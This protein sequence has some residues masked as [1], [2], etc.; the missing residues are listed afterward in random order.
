SEFPNP[1]P[2]WPVEVFGVLQ[3]AREIGGDLYDFY[4]ID[5]RTLGVVVADVCEKGAPAALFMAHTSSMLRVVTLLMAQLGS[6]PTPSAVMEQVNEEMCRVNQAGMFVT[7]FFAMLDMQSGT[8]SFC[9]AGHPMP[10]RLGADG[11][12]GRLA[13]TSGI[14][15]GIEAGMQYETGSTRIEPGD[16]FFLYTDG[17]TEAMNGQREFFGEIRLQ[18]ALASLTRASP[19]SMV[20]TVV[21]RVR[22][23]VAGAPQADDIA[24]IAVRAGLLSAFGNATGASQ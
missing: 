17:V 11:G 5:D 6:L 1:T 12:I 18:E 13:G 4:R 23:F 24:V 20:D 9:S 21:G 16:A 15:V 3:T 14:P 2:D 10:Y 22:E 8:L 19:R 7:V